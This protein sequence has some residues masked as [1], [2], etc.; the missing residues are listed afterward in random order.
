MKNNP[1][2]QTIDTD[3][4]KG[5]LNHIQNISLEDVAKFHGH[6]CDG[7][8]VGFLG[9]KEALNQLYPDKIVDRTNTRIVSKS[10]PCLTDVAIYLT[11]GRYQFNTFYVDNSIAYNYIIQRMDND[12]ALGVKLAKGVKPSIIDEMG[13]KAVAQKLSPCELDELKKLEDDFSEKLLSLNPKEAFVID[14]IE[15]FNWQPILENHFIKTDTINK[16]LAKCLKQTIKT[17]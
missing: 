13:D 6:L 2:I 8:V 16:N 1:T 5:R 3:F 7:L 4:S 11:G 14:K 12:F 10:S 9:L 15:N 17:K